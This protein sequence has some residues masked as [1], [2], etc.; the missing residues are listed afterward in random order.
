MVKIRERDVYALVFQCGVQLQIISRLYDA[1]A[2]KTNCCVCVHVYETLYIVL[3]LEKFR[4][5]LSILSCLT[6]RFAYQRTNKP[7]EAMMVGNEKKKKIKKGEKRKSLYYEL[8]K[9]EVEITST[10][11]E[12]ITAKKRVVF[13]FA[14]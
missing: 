10:C 5:L 11:C 6:L 3:K 12:S 2:N 4:G 13:F 7:I 14:P 1:S 8:R 9:S